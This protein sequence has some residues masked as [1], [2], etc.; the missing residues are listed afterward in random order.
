MTNDVRRKLILCVA[1]SVLFVGRGSSLPFP[2]LTADEVFALGLQAMEQE[3]WG[4]AAQS[5]GF[6]LASPGF[7]RPQE[8]RLLLAEAQFG[9]ELYI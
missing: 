7:T 4:E 3:N 1:S 8:A 9:D 2:G 5:F 6:V